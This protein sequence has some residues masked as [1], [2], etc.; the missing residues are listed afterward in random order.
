M[1][2]NSDLAQQCPALTEPP[3]QRMQLLLLFYRQAPLALWKRQARFSENEPNPF[4][5][6]LNTSYQPSEL[7][8][9]L[10]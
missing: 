8:I 7:A 3:K 4:G 2:L 9:R 5:A 10:V 1:P 6:N